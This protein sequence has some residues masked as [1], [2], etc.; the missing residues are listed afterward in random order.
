MHMGMALPLIEVDEAIADG[1][2]TGAGAG[3]QGMVGGEDGLLGDGQTMW[4]TDMVGCTTP[5]ASLLEWTVYLL[6]VRIPSEGDWE[7]NCHFS[8]ARADLPPAGDWDLNIYATAP[9]L[10]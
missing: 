3:G 1:A 5:S 6:L 2:G 7:P 10:T 4:W 9:E 8:G